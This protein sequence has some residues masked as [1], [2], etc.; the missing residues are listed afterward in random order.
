M[1]PP[2]PTTTP[3]A[4]SREPEIK[5]RTTRGR[6]VR[7]SSFPFGDGHGMGSAVSQ[8]KRPVLLFFFLVSS[9]KGL[10]RPTPKTFRRDRTSNKIHE[11]KWRPQL[12]F[13]IH[14]RK[15]QW[16]T[17][18]MGSGGGGERRCGYMRRIARRVRVWLPFVSL[19]SH[20]GIIII[21]IIRPWNKAIAQI[22]RKKY[23]RG[24]EAVWENVRDERFFLHRTA[25]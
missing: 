9:T 1:V 15:F 12:A 13:A 20:R 17:T 21:I 2:P 22:D 11:K 3:P 18:G 14:T 19:R 5:V 16:E 7:P 8:K 23:M 10:T 4:P 24:R 25:S 6:S